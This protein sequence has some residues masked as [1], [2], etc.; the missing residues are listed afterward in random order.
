MQ[1]DAESGQKFRPITMGAL[2]LSTV[3]PAKPPLTALKTTSGSSP[4]GRQHERLAHRGYVAC[5]HNLIRELGNVAA[6]PGQQCARTH[7][8]EDG[9]T[10]SE[11]QLRRRP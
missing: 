11:R 9:L 5:H 8:F 10:V 1:P 3:L 6:R 2:A 7:L 4:A